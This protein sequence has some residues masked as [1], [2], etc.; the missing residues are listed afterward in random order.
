[1]QTLT[2]EIDRPGRDLE[3]QALQI[4][5]E[6]PLK[7]GSLP[8]ADLRLDDPGVG[9]LHAVLTP[10]DGYA[11]LVDL[12]TRGGTY[13]NGVRIERARVVAGDEILV[14]TTRIRLYFG[15]RPKILTLPAVP[16]TV[17]AQP[18]QSSV[19]PYFDA[20]PQPEVAR[21]SAAQVEGAAV[22]G[23][24]HPALPPEPTLSANFRTLELRVYWG[25]VLLDV[26]H[27]PR[28]KPV[29]IGEARGTD[30]FLTS[31]NLPV[32]SFPLLRSRGGEWLLTFSDQMEGE[33]E[34][35]GRLCSLAEIAGSRLSERDPDLSG[36]ASVELGTDTRA[37]LHW[38]GVSFAIRFVPP[39]APVPRGRVKSLDFPFLN[40]LLVAS[41]LHVALI[42]V[43]LLYPYDLQAIQE[44]HGIDGVI[45]LTRPRVSASTTRPPAAAPKPSDLKASPES[46]SMARGV[47]LEEARR[48]LR[49]GGSGL[50]REVAEAKI[51]ERIRTI[52]GRDS[53][54][55]SILQG[56]SPMNLAGALTDM[57]G[58]VAASDVGSMHGDGARG[59]G[60]I[61]SSSLVGCDGSGHCGSRDIEPIGLLGGHGRCTKGSCLGRGLGVRTDH[62]P[63]ISFKPPTFGDALPRDVIRK[64]IDENK[65]QIR[66]CY[67]RELQKAVTL[68]GL[69]RVRFVIGATG[70]VAF[71]LVTET[72]LD[73]LTVEECIR[74]KISGWSFPPPAGGGR[75]E[76]NYPFILHSTDG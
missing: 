72:T 5:H 68:E 59:D 61:G 50:S 51:R 22:S 43:L 44:Q 52:F 32:E 31:E 34:V 42:T 30:V 64:V 2:L 54:G 55:S 24:P 71:V 58:T 57:I 25:Q 56:Q 69:V 20:E 27:Y 45:E 16:E 18:P 12:G 9:R 49:R 26:R 8:S 53:L 21:I 23:R 3:T 48:P 41:C 65:G 7:I 76:V 37:L 13:V 15:L 66:Y 39:A 33:L 46:P 29:R 35:E 38:G 14:G 73:N 62:A 11:N 74:E 40:T 17:V 36:C 19:G 63:P 75:V 6:R 10:G 4:G 28:P 47:S 70:R 60:P 1:M 67:E